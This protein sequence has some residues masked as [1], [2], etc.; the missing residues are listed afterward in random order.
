MLDFKSFRTAGSVLTGI[1]LVHMIRKGQLAVNCV[2]ATSL[3]D[4]FSTLAGMIR[5]K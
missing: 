5:P 3:A 1:E 2:D 4:Q